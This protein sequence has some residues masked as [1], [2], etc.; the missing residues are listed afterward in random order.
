MNG[1]AHSAPLRQHCQNNEDEQSWGILER[2]HVVDAESELSD[3]A[4]TWA[5]LARHKETDMRVHCEEQY[6][7]TDDEEGY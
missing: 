1:T 4:H 7:C 3:A 2:D 6:E 5:M